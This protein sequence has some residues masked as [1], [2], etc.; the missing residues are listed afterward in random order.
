MQ[1]NLDNATCDSA[2]VD[3]LIAAFNEQKQ[4]AAEDDDFEFN[5]TTAL[6]NCTQVCVLQQ[7]ALGRLHSI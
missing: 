2:W 1:F 7:H 6:V 4:K 5:F 3:A